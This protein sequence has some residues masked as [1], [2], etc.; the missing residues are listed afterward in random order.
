MSNGVGIAVFIRVLC[1]TSRSVHALSHE[2]Y[3]WRSGP[4]VYNDVSG[5]SSL[6]CFAES[7]SLT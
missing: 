3:E 4:F 7:F 2:L 6:G 5:A 1:L